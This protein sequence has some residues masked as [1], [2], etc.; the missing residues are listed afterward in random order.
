[1]TIADLINAHPVWFWLIIIIFS[2][3]LGNI[4]NGLKAIAK[5]IENRDEQIF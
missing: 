1:M 2:I 4:A 5:A 3:D